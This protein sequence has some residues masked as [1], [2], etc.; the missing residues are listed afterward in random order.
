M[1]NV[2]IKRE[3]RR[4]SAQKIMPDDDAHNDDEDEP[5]PSSKKKGYVCKCF[6][7]T[8][9][10]AKNEQDAREKCKRFLIPTNLNA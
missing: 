2:E 4:G 9:V 8:K 10:R 6:S 5:E 7:R 1:K 3:K